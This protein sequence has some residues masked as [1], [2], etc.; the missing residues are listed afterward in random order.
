MGRSSMQPN[1]VLVGYDWSDVGEH[2]LTWALRYANTTASQLHV[3]VA[4]DEQHRVEA[5]GAGPVDFAYTERLH[6]LLA[7][8]L[9]GA[10]A[11]LG[12]AAAID[13]AVHVRIGKPA[14]E[15]LMVAGEIGADLIV[16]G[17]HGKTG[18]RRMVQGSVSEAVVRGAECPVMVVRPKTYSDVQRLDV[19][20]TPH[21]H[22]H[23][24]PHIYSYQNASVTKRP[25]D[26][27]LW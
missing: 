21:G 19:A 10:C 23:R 26:W 16:V 15:V 20:A 13:Y 3:L 8:K 11:A 14:H 7:S 9:A 2:A 24:K 12:D 6:D 25:S 5:A 22:H 27:P 17:S 4:V 18:L 1:Q